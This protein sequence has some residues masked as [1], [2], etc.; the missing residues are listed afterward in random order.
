MS[1]KVSTLAALGAFISSGGSSPPTAN[2]GGLAGVYK[3]KAI[4]VNV[5][6]VFTNTIPTSAYRGA[7]RPEASFAIERIIDHA[8]FKLNLDPAFL[9][10]IPAVNPEIPPP[11]ILTGV[12]F[13]IFN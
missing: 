11:N 1:L 4:Y 6:G 13:E 8:A 12:C 2:L 3:T 7:G 10:K 5:K 9:R